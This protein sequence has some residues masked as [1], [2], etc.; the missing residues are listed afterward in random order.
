MIICRNIIEESEI[1]NMKII[2]VYYVKRS[3][4]GMNLR[5]MLQS[6]TKFKNCS[7]TL[8]IYSVVAAEESNITIQG[9]FY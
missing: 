5:L 8:L 9:Y 4:R 7:C 6:L 1:G 3:N 2:F